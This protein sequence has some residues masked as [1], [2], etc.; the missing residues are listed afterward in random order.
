VL[1]E[2]SEY[3]KA[4]LS[5]SFA[6]SPK[7]DLR[8]SGDTSTPSIHSFR[9]NEDIEPTILDVMVRFV[10]SF[11]LVELSEEEVRAVV[12]HARAF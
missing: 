7:R 12:D 1:S 6:E 9:I 11:E 3:F 10:Y 5:S 2:Q 8:S 4:M